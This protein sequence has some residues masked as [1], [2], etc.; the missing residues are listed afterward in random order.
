MTRDEDGGVW[1]F[2]G[3]SELCAKSK[4]SDRERESD[5]HTHTC[6]KQGDRKV[7]RELGAHT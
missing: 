2:D 6:R 3:T 4:R 7:A 5:C 1:D